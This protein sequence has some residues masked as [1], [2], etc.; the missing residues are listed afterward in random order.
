MSANVASILEDVGRETARSH[1]HTVLAVSVESVQ[2]QFALNHLS[3]VIAV[4]GSTCTST[5]DVW[6]EFVQFFA[7]LISYG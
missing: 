5:E 2:L 4:G 3:D 1:L 7:V 6:S